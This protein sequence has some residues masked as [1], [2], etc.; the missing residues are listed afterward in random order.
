VRFCRLWY[1]LQI[2]VE[3]EEARRICLSQA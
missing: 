3:P 2:Q 1:I